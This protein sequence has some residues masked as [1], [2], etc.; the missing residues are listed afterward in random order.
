MPVT[1]R[2][3]DRSSITRESM[4]PEATVM[5]P[6][7]SGLS[8]VEDSTLNS[9]N[10]VRGISSI[11]SEPISNIR[12]DREESTVPPLTLLQQHMGVPELRELI[13]Q[14]SDTQS[15]MM[16]ILQSLIEPHSGRNLNSLHYQQLKVPDLN[17]IFCFHGF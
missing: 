13:G 16:E 4:E 8:T 9:R 11:G 10:E 15:S 12:D 6:S 7:H 5:E 2:S 17:T 1:T 3:R 14:L